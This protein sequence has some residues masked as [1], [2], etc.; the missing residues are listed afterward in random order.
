MTK[1]MNPSEPELMQAYDQGLTAIRQK[2]IKYTGPAEDLFFLLPLAIAS[3]PGNPPPPESWPSY[4]TLSRNGQ[5]AVR[6]LYL[7]IHINDFLDLS[8]KFPKFMEAVIILHSAIHDF[9]NA[10]GHLPLTGKELGDQPKLGRALGAAIRLVQ[11]V[12]LVKIPDD[13]DARPKDSTAGGDAGFF[14]WLERNRDPDLWHVI[15]ANFNYD[16]ECTMD[17]CKWVIKQPDCDRATAAWIFLGCEGQRYVGKSRADLNEYGKIIE[18]IVSISEGRGYSRNELSLSSMGWEDDQRPLLKELQQRA[19]EDA[20]I[21]VPVKLLSEP[22][23]GR[24]PQTPYAVHSEC[25]VESGF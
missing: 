5:L 24:S 7:A 8:L 3:A 9:L 11:E 1:T 17:F 2:A 18:E 6:I 12:N 15:V 13:W 25:I 10:P 21:P 16:L 14:P 22:F 19:T 4:A 20:G 23:H